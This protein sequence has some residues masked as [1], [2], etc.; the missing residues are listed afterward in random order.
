VIS[1][2]IHVLN[3]FHRRHPHAQPVGVGDLSLPHG[4][5][6]GPEVGGGI[7][8]ITH[9]NGLDVDVYYPRRDRRER[10]PLTVGQV[11]VRRSQALV[12]MFVD[13]GAVTIYV[14]P[15]L[16]L[17]GPPAVVTPLVNH[18]NHMHVRIAPPPPGGEP[19]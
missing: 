15:N 19:H 10:A 6:F 18:D 12:D 17:T 2:T 9:Q 1:T 11:D 16:P 3:D 5:Y 4:G 14:G 7:G 8:H 13:A